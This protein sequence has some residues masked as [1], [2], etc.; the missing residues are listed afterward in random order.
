MV[1]EDAD[2]FLSVAYVELVPVLI[3]AFKEHIDS[4]QT[5]QKEMKETLESLRQQG[6]ASK[7]IDTQQTLNN[8]SQQMSLLVSSL[9]KSKSSEL[10]DLE[11]GIGNE[12]PEKA[13]ISKKISKRK[14]FFVKGA[15]GT[16]CVLVFLLCAV[17]VPPILL[18]GESHLLL[19]LI[20]SL[21][22]S[23]F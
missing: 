1:T 5:D 10:V 14:S 19:C 11:S 6:P 2:G 18:H 21:S 3:A 9:N 12:K 16:A 20:L 7:Q 23:L 17:V 22:L 13:E 4:Y 8:L 15:I